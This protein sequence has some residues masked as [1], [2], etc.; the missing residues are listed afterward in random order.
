MYRF[1]PGP[2]LGPPSHLA[3]S[4]ASSPSAL[5]CWARF[6]KFSRTHRTSALHSSPPSGQPTGKSDEGGMGVLGGAVDENRGPQLTSAR[7][8]PP[9][10]R[11]QCTDS[12]LGRPSG[13]RRI[14]LRPP[15][16]HRPH[17]RVGPDLKSSPR[18]HRTSALHSPPPSG[19]PTGKS[20]EGGMG[21]LGG[22]VDEN[23]GPQLTS[24]LLIPPSERL[25]CTDSD[26]GRPSGRRRISLRPPL[27]HRPH[28]RVGP[29]LK[30]S[31]ARIAPRLCIRL[32]RAASPR[33]NLMKG[34]WGC[35]AGRSTR[36]VGPN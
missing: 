16:P 17:L 29:D 4:A 18:T 9:S 8:I 26:L 25:Q 14:S 3:P 27:P 35:W 31:P 6:E 1:R 21:V 33:G 32:H 5:A 11:L 34:G 7:L 20:D 24:A 30:S 22:A 15:L 28:L 10:E 13:R 23:R 19:Q 2:P 36:I 12:D